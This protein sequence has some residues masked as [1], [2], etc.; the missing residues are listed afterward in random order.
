MANTTEHK[1]MT[2]EKRKKMEDLIYRFFSA[3]DPSGVN[4]SFYQSKFKYMTNKEKQNL[5]M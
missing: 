4:T 3:M 5:T 2:T 1:P